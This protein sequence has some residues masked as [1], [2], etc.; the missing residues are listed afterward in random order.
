MQVIIDGIK[1]APQSEVSMMPR[2]FGDF[3]RDARKSVKLSLEAASSEVPCS[4]SYLWEME[5]GTSEP[6]LRV[7]SGIARAYG[8][9]LETLASYLPK[10]SNA[11]YTEQVLHK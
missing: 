9:K 2:S 3:L 4:K 11:S 6:S 5:N 1:Y 7:A 8:L 10:V